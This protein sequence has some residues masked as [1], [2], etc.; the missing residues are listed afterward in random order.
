MQSTASTPEVRDRAYYDAMNDDYDRQTVAVMQRSLTPDSNAVDVGCHIGSI[1]MPI[2]Q[3]A[4]RGT[5]YGFEPLP[6]LYQGLIKTFPKQTFPKVNFYDLALSDTQGETSF[7]HVTSNPAYSGLRRRRYD[8]PNETVVEITVKTDLLD[9]IVPANVPIH[10]IK[11]DVEGGEF[12]VL[13]GGIKT[14]SKNRPVIVFEHGEAGFAYYGPTT[15]KI[16]DLLSDCGLQI[17][18]MKTWLNGGQPFT[19]EEFLDA[20][21]NSGHWYYMA[22]RPHAEMRNGPLLPGKGEQI[23]KAPKMAKV[24]RSVNRVLN[25]FG[26]RV[27]RLSSYHSLQRRACSQEHSERHEQQIRFDNAGLQQLVAELQ[28]QIKQLERF[29]EE[30][31]ALSDTVCRLQEKVNSSLLVPKE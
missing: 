18:F 14:I 23:P 31:A 25:V 2:L 17:S 30:N 21:H 11:I 22:H 29:R 8:R 16:F 7:C 12:L 9:H 19:R 1:L 27:M 6:D 26:A 24:G 4:P 15:L 5:H 28:Q 13:N 10:F 20:Y 3:T